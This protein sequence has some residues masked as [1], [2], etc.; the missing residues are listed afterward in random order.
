M[1]LTGT[2]MFCRHVTSLY[3][4]SCTCARK[5]A[6]AACE[7]GPAWR[8]TSHNS[9]VVLVRQECGNSILCCQRSC[10]GAVPRQGSPGLGLRRPGRQPQ[11]AGASAGGSTHRGRCR[12]RRSRQCVAAGGRPG[13]AAAAGWLGC[14]GHRAGSGGSGRRRPRPRARRIAFAARSRRGCCAEWRGRSMPRQQCPPSRK[15]FYFLF[16]RMFAVTS[17]LRVLVLAAD[18]T[19][20]APPGA[21]PAMEEQVAATLSTLADLAASDVSSVGLRQRSDSANS[22]TSFC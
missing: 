21:S 7:Y 17:S 9:N 1:Q 6:V 13:T 4:K 8:T 2:R 12:R 5:N 22:G 15:H 14:D 16:L 20:A 10:G 18:P 3:Q 19:P 11:A